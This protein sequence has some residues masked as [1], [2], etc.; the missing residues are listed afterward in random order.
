MFVGG[1][2]LTHCH[3]TER[4]NSGGR[5]NISLTLCPCGR[6]WVKS[7]T[8][9]STEEEEATILGQLAGELGIEKVHPVV[10]VGVLILLRVIW[11]S[12]LMRVL[13]RLLEVQLW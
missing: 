8:F 7:T 4:G 12:M 11:A 2:D 6:G 13:L 10:F 3:V 9:D 5:P 1:I